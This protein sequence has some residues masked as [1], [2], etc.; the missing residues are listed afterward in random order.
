MDTALFLYSIFFSLLSSSGHL[1]RPGFGPLLGNSEILRETM[2]VTTMT[3]TTT[4]EIFATGRAI[5]NAVDDDEGDNGDM[6]ESAA[7][8]RASRVWLS[9]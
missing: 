4:R 6:N 9:L 8:A 1:E 5:H 3:T 7:S 2:M